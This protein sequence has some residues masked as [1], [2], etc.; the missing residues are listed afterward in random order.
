MVKRIREETRKRIV[1]A[2]TNVFFHT[3][4]EKAG[5]R[6]VAKQAG[7]S[8]RCVYKYFPSKETLLVSVASEKVGQMV[9]ELKQHL[10]GV[11]G[12]E[13]KLSK[14][15]HYYLSTY[16]EDRKTAWLVYVSTNLTI[17]RRYPT[18]WNNLQASAEIFRNLV[19]EGQ[20]NGEVRQDID[21]RTVSNL[22]FGGLRHEV[23]FWLINQPTSSLISKADEITETIFNAIKIPIEQPMPFVCPFVDT[24]KGLL[25]PS[26]NTV[27]EPK[28]VPKTL[29]VGKDN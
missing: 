28:D 5:M 11:R 9:I 26:V 18:G 17:W 13:S 2:A 29:G 8:A 22:Y 3:D 23:S 19:R 20:T 15:T 25:S 14:M 16:E 24:A 12:A 7:V 21:I 10:S 1:N 4:F 6:G 27:S